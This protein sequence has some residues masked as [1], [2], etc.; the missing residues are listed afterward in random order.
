MCLPFFFGTQPR[1]DQKEEEEKE[2]YVH[3]AHVFKSK[4]VFILSSCCVFE[5]QWASRCEPLINYPRFF[6]SLRKAPQKLRPQGDPWPGEVA[7]HAGAHLL[8]RQE[9]GQ[10]EGADRERH[11]GGDGGRL[12][13]AVSE[14]PESR[15]GC[16]FLQGEGWADDSTDAGGGEKATEAHCCHTR[17]KKGFSIVI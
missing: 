16:N 13:R 11:T 15:L 12:G 1:R 6:P 9:E 8:Q 17:K 14:F 7:A 5:L 10:E 2:R 4:S 3:K